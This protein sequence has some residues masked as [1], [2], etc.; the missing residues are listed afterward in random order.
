MQRLAL[1]GCGRVTTSRYVEVCRDE[2]RNA[3]VVV[4]CDIVPERANHVAAALRCDAAYELERVL[5]RRDVDVVVILTESGRHYAHAI[6]ALDAGKHVIVEKPPAMLPSEIEEC[7]RVAD[8]AGR[9]YAPIV[10]NRFN[11]AMRALHAAHTEGRF[12]RRVL[13][14]IRLRWCRHQQYYEDGWHGTWSMDGGVINQQAFHHVDALQW[15]CGPVSEVVAAQSN[16]LNKLEAEDTSVA[17]LRMADG[18]LALIEATTAARPQDFEASISIVAE[19]GMVEVGGIA[20]NKIV[21][22]RFV[23]AR[24]DDANVPQLHSQDVPTGY[25]LSHGPL[26][27]EILDRLERGAI[28]PPIRSSDVIPTVELVH[29]L[30]RSTEVGGWVRMKDRPLSERLGRQAGVA[31]RTR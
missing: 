4:A 12:G 15:I 7:Q 10:Q 11:P 14:T 28:D 22:W 29:A 23:D 24:P 17:T 2:L 25:G 3:Q 1:I 6:Q 5:E 27:Q 31:Q 8:R 26:L 20:L 19:G 16:A 13:S 30:Y 21:Q 18:S 9:M